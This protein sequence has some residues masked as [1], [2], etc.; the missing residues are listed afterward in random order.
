MAGIYAGEVRAGGEA[1]GVEGQ[2]TLKTTPDYS[3]DCGWRDM[4][5]KFVATEASRKRV[6][7]HKDVEWYIKQQNKNKKRKKGTPEKVVPKPVIADGG[8]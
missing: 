6:R 2:D 3:F 7:F 5:L 8:E 4:T 1:Q